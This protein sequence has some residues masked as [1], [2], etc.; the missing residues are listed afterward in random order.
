METKCPYCGSMI[1]EDKFER[2]KNYCFYRPKKSK[3]KHQT[4]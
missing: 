4:K 3:G 1:D 2:H